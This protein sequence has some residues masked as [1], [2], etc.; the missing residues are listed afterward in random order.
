MK[1]TKPNQKQSW[2]TRQ[3][4]N[5]S[6]SFFSAMPLMMVGQSCLGSITALYS[7]KMDNYE[8][9]AIAAVLTMASNAAFIAQVNP[10]WAV[11][12]FNVSIAVNALL[13]ILGLITG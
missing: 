5:Y 4:D 6:E 13:I 12:I 7:L 2:F 3:V 1:S 9:L 8:F 11:G 10:K